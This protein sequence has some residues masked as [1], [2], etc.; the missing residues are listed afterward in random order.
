MSSSEDAKKYL[1]T[2]VLSEQRT[3]S[4]RNVARALQ[5]HV[6]AAKC[7]LWEFYEFQRA[8]KPGSIHA[9]YLLS[10]VKKQSS[11]TQNVSKGYDEDEPIPSSP[12]PFTSSMLEPEASQ[13]ESEAAP[14]PVR[15][16]IL[17]RDDSLQGM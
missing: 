4:Y 12:P 8:K 6:N 7:L 11:T 1:A 3:V 9:T 2:E 16:V 5:V 14:I 17:V 15:T 10:G 13:Q